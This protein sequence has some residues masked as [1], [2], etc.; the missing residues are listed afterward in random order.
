M[1]FTSGKNLRQSPRF[2]S[3]RSQ[4][5]QEYPYLPPEDHFAAG[6]GSRDKPF[7]RDASPESGH[8]I[9]RHGPGGSRL[10]QLPYMVPGSDITVFAFFQKGSFRT[11]RVISRLA[12]CRYSG[13]RPLEIIRI[14]CRIRCFSALAPL[15]TALLL[16]ITVGAAGIACFP[17]SRNFILYHTVFVYAVFRLFFIR[18]I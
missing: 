10:A 5:Q 8:S 11:F 14:S 7:G 12:S 9:R 2:L 15:Y 13:D 4:S 18:F 1:K 3:R 16:R 6:P 17:Y